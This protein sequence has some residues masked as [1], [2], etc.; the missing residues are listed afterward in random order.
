[1]RRLWLLVA[2][3]KEGVGGFCPIPPRFLRYFP[4]ADM[5]SSS[6]R[7]MFE[8]VLS[9]GCVCVCGC[10]RGCCVPEEKVLLPL[11]LPPL[12]LLLLLLL[13]P[14]PLLLLL[15]LPLP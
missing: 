10:S 11:L 14:Q 13:L 2:A 15:L 5:V 12:L 4:A 7:I 9:C 1:M 6:L 3:D 8:E